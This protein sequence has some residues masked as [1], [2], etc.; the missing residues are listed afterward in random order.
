[1]MQDEE[2]HVQLGKSLGSLGQIYL[3]F[4]DFDAAEESFNKAIYIFSQTSARDTPLPASSMIFLCFSLHQRQDKEE[5]IVL[6]LIKAFHVAV[7]VDLVTIAL[8]ILNKII[9]V[10]PPS[11]QRL[12]LDA[13]KGCLPRLRGHPDSIDSVSS[14]IISLDKRVVGDNTP[15]Y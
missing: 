7:D 11:L 5:D 2:S 13:A 6:W 15:R 4:R 10:V 1:M 9:V 8:T 3:H 12:A 14:T